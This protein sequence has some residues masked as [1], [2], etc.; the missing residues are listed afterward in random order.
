MKY[1]QHIVN[2]SY[3]VPAY[4]VEKNYYRLNFSQIYPE[5]RGI[6]FAIKEAKKMVKLIKYNENG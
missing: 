1:A 5:D 2:R 4:E 6:N 3:K